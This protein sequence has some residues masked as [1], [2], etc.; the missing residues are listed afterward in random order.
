MRWRWQ[1][2]GWRRRH[3][4]SSST[5]SDSIARARCPRYCATRDSRCRRPRT[6]PPRCT[7]RDAPARPRRA[8]RDASRPRRLRGVSPYRGARR[9]CPCLF[10]TARDATEDQRPRPDARGRRLHGQAVQPGGAASRA[11]G[12]SLRRTRGGA[13]ASGRSSSYDD[14]ELNEDAREVRRDG[15]RRSSSPRPST[16]CSTIC[17]QTP[18]ASSQQGPD[19]R[20]RL[21]VRLQRRL[22]RG[23][24]LHQLP[25]QED[26]PRRRRGADPDGARLRLLHPPAPPVADD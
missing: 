19:P 6:V 24:D 2:E 3:G 18:A 21:A 9:A 13:E 20:P 23:R 22:E 16:T 11:C 10:L 25:P 12:P 5:T 4:C 17:S 1:K 26:R 15:P 14:L 8:R 7:R